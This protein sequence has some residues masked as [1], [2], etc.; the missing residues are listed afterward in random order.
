M[1]S[2]TGKIT[3]LPGFCRIKR[4]SGS[5]PVIL[6]DSGG[7]ACQK[8]SLV[9]LVSMYRNL[10]PV[11][12]FNLTGPAQPPHIIAVNKQLLVSCGD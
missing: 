3:V 7:L 9:A 6:A 10:I 12:S 8:T 11:D 5:T 4:G 1:R 2:K